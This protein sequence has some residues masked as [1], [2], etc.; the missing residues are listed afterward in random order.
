MARSR[1]LM[2]GLL[3]ALALGAQGCM[4]YRQTALGV[5]PAPD[6][7]NMSQGC[8]K[9]VWSFF[10]GLAAGGEPERPNCGQVGL[11]EVTVRSTP[12]LFLVSL[13]TVGLVTPRRVDW[14]CAAPAPGGGVIP[15]PVASGGGH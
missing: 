12:P 7:P 11:Q 2:L 13:V 1:I 8:S 4:T 5:T 14:K 3:A 6:C 15:G 9:T 10:W